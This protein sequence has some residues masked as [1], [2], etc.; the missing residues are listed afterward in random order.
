LRRCAASSY[1]AGFLGRV[2]QFALPNPTTG[3]HGF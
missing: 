1:A 3:Y 2:G